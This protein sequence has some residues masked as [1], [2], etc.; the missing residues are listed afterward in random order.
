MTT[1]FEHPPIVARP[2]DGG[3]WGNIVQSDSTALTGTRNASAA[4][5][6]LLLINGSASNYTITLPAGMA[7]DFGFALVQS[8]TGT[9]T[10]AAGAGV[11][12]IGATLATTSAGDI[13]TVIWVSA[14]TYIIK[15]S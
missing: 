8:S 3:K 4:D 5:D 1:D 10:I 12:F 2:A 14:N 9:C 15:V 13:L 6:G 7:T 11:T